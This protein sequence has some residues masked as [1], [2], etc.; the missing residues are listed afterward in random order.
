MRAM[1]RVGLWLDLGRF[2]LAALFG[3]WLVAPLLG[4]SRGFVRGWVVPALS[5][6]TRRQ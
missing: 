2:V 6:G 1:V 3:A 5:L 4:V